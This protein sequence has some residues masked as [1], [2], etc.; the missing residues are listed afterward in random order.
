MNF[1]NK[2]AY[3][4]MLTKIENLF[5]WVHWVVIRGYNFPITSQ[6]LAMQTYPIQSKPPMYP[7]D[8]PNSK[9]P[10]TIDLPYILGLV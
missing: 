2:K 6:G 8:S 7:L 9:I 5:H 3:Y 4:W 10:K 1:F